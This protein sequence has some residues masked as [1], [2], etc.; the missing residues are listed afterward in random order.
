MDEVQPAIPQ[1]PRRRLKATAL[2]VT[3]LLIGGL[4]A[5][6]VIQQKQIN[7]LRD[8]RS[9]N[10][11]KGCAEAQRIAKDSLAVKPEP[12]YHKAATTV[13]QNP[14]CFSIDDRATAQTWLDQINSQ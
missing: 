10:M 3:G 13:M 6:V 5:A 9:A 11:K 8:G 4:I 12:N 2:A 1:R 7:D 14:P